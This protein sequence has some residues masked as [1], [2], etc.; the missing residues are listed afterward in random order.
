MIIPWWLLWVQ[1]MMTLLWCFL[2]SPSLKA[3][4]HW[5]LSQLLRK[6]TSWRKAGWGLISHI[7]I[8]FVYEPVHVY[9]FWFSFYL[10]LPPILCQPSTYNP[11]PL[12]LPTSQLNA[13]LYTA[14]IYI[15]ISLLVFGFGESKRICFLAANKINRLMPVSVVLSVRVQSANSLC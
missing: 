2:I 1:W 9:F 4:S 10:L 8:K 11:R 15:Y 14:Y 5:R 6:K 7:Q 12:P 13:L 3:P